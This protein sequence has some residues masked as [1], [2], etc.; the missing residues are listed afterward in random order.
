MTATLQRSAGTPVL[1]Q[2]LARPATPPPTGRAERPE[3]E[4][5]APWVF[6]AMALSAAAVGTVQRGA[7]SGGYFLDEQWRVDFVRSSDSVERM[8]THDTPVPLGWVYAMKALAPFGHNP[9]LYRVVVAGTYVVAAGVLALLFLRIAQRGGPRIPPVV[10]AGAVG[11]LAFSPVVSHPYHYVSNYP[12]EILYVALLVLA[13]EEL[14]RHRL[15]PAALAV[16]LA[17]APLFVLGGLL[18]VPALVACFAWWARHDDPVRRDRRTAV[19]A[20]AAALSAVLAI[21]VFAALVRP[22]GTRPSI[23]E[24]WVSL[25]ESLGGDASVVDLLGR[26]VHGAATGLAGDRLAAAPGWLWAATC[27]VLAGSF[28]IGAWVVVRRWP[29]LGAITGSAYA[30]AVVA[31]ALVHWPMT[32]Q[33]VNLCFAI[34]ALALV[35]IGLLRAVAWVLPALDGWAVVP[36]LLLVL[37]ATWPSPWGLGDAYSRGMR[38][39]LEAVWPLAAPRN[40]VLSYHRFSHFYTHDALVNDA[41]PGETFILE[42]ESWDDPDTIYR[43]PAGLLARHDLRAGDMVW[44]VMPWMMGDSIERAC[45]LGDVVGVDLWEAEVIQGTDALIRGFVVLGGA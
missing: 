45:Q 14:G 27:V 36:A 41:P 1:D 31:S 40:V 23:G 22:V 42:F 34:L 2:P 11:L 29:W 44:C 43:D 24:F 6:F 5:L 12:A 39:D 35:W 33:R 10:P 26:T 38:A 4:Q 13:A 15:A 16:L 28:A 30:L 21:G 17:G 20:A 19:V 18:V 37:H 3:R 9:E 25:G 8:L 32:L 7:W